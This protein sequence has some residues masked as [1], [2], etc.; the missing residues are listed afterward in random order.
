MDSSWSISPASTLIYFWKKFI[1]FCE[2]CVWSWQNVLQLSTVLLRF[3]GYPYND[4]VICKDSPDYLEVVE[5]SQIK[6]IKMLKLSIGN[7]LQVN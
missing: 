3:F 2:N 5:G 7:E 4:L 1:F 6:T